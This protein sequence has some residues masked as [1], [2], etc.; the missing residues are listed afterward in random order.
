M[1]DELIHDDSKLSND[2]LMDI[3]KLKFNGNSLFHVYAL[4]HDVL[5]IIFNK[6]KHYIDMKGDNEKPILLYVV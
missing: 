1:L 4:N 2:I 3:L 5:T 6:V